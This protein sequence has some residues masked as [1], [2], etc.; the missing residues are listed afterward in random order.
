[1]KCNFLCFGYRRDSVQRISQEQPD[2]RRTR[3]IAEEAFNQL[4]QKQSDS[5]S[6]A[7]FLQTSNGQLAANSYDTIV[8]DPND[9][10][11]LTDNIVRAYKERGRAQESGPSF[12]D[13]ESALPVTTVQSLESLN[14]S[15]DT[16]TI[17]KSQ[18]DTDLRKQTTLYIPKK[19]FDLLA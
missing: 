11:Q 16:L 6:D 2:S 7:G 14:S 19:S 17:K 12:S 4:S 1:M 9:S 18:S 3:E 10:K 5:I 15:A 8:T 13:S